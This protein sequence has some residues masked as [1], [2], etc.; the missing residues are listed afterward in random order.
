MISQSNKTIVKLSELIIPKYYDNFND[1]K[2]THQIY[3][4]GRAGT[5]SSRGALRAVKRIIVSQPGSVV[6]MRKFHNKLKKD[7]VC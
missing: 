2:H 3:T 7:S 5:K 1:I 4:S 6:I